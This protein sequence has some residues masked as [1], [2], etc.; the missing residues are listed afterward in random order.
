MRTGVA[1][2]ELLPG[3]VL[4]V[5]RPELLGGLVLEIQRLERAVTFWTDAAVA[6]IHVGDGRDDVKMLRVRQEI[7]EM[8]SEKIRI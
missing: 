4:D 6:E 7:Q 3:Q 2:E 1:V 8:D 5:R